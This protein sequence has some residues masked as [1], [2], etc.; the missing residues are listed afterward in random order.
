MSAAHPGLRG[1][2]NSIPYISWETRRVMPVARQFLCRRG[3]WR[4]VRGSTVSHYAA[5]K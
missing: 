3:H 1:G 2:V 5:G 4:K